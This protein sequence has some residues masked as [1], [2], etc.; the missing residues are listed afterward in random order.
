MD[1]ISTRE[2]YIIIDNL[3]S[4][5][6]NELNISWLC[7]YAGVS[8]SGFYVWKSKQNNV[9]QKEQKDRQDFELILEAYNYRGY[10]KGSR[11]IY[12]R[13]LHKGVR[14]NRKKIIRLMRKYNLFCPIRKANPYKKM[15]KAVELATVADNIVN[16]NF[17]EY[18]PRIILLTDITY[19]FY[20]K[21]K[22]AYLSSIKD[23]YT[24][25]ILAWVLSENMEEDF[26]L[27]TIN[28]LMLNYGNEL[29]T[30]SLVHSDQGVH[31]K[32][33]SFQQLLK[34][35]NLRQS[36]S[37]KANCWDNAP[38]ESFHGH[39]K[40]EINLDNCST[41]EELKLIIEDYID[42]YNNDRYQWDLAKL[43][44]SEYYIYCIT[45]DYPLDIN[46]KDIT[47]TQ[48]K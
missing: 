44:P 2:R 43:A 10:D 14:M 33:Y 5:D 13:L 39:M 1:E 22:K 30:D 4:N 45:G 28:I 9:T 17:R 16:R 34:D 15:A 12:M 23:A 21:C 27:E 11:G 42:Y 40:D 32:A 6:N 38:Q 25:E 31:Y 26:V 48:K 24:K 46:K 36:M 18:G 29:K 20:G 7:E 41:F 35:N 47:N 3:I 37:R 8:R 19:L